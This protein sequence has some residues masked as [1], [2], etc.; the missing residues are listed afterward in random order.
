MN[1]SLA[2]NSADQETPVDLVSG[3]DLFHTDST[4]CFPKMVGGVNRFLQAS[5]KKSLIPSRRHSL[6]IHFSKAPPFRFLAVGVRFPHE[7]GAI[8][9]SSVWEAAAQCHWHKKHVLHAL[10]CKE[11]SSPPR[12]LKRSW[13]FQGS[14]GHTCSRI[15]HVLT[16]SQFPSL[17]QNDFAFLP[18]WWICS[19]L[20]RLLPITSLPEQSVCK[21]AS[22]DLPFPSSHGHFLPCP[23]RNMLPKRAWGSKRRRG[24][25]RY[26]WMRCEIS[27]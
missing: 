4:F 7:S 26:I 9:T 6:C 23:S 18:P 11:Q 8:S 25:G 24:S 1:K 17:D 21:R 13:G 12:L 2:D 27:T 5:I 16:R 22:C 19:A 3:G 14:T 10:L 20:H 15:P